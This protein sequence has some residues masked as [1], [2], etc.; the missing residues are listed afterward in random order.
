MENQI[1]LVA[2]VSFL[3]DEITF[4]NGFALSVIQDLDKRLII[5]SSFDEEFV[6]PQTGQ[7]GVDVFL[8]ALPPILCQNTKLNLN[9]V[10]KLRETSDSLVSIRLL[11]H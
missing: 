11:H 10:G 1:K 9:H 8:S 3:K 6:L 7:K 4:C 5:K 2:E